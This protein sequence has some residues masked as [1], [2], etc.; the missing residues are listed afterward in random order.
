MSRDA[1][2]P[3]KETFRAHET[4]SLPFK[5]LSEQMQLYVKHAIPLLRGS[6]YMFLPPQSTLPNAFQKVVSG[7]LPGQWS[8]KYSPPGC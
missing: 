5:V 4:S 3:S 6:E 8:P 1:R 2:G 7:G